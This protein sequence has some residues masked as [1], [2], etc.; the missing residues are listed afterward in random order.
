M[1]ILMSGHPDFEDRRA[2]GELK[3]N[4]IL[5]LVSRRDYALKKY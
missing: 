3:R 4:L 2:F 5:Q 1:V